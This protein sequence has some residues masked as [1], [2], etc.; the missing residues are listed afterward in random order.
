[1]FCDHYTESFLQEL[2]N[3]NFVVTST[4]LY[5]VIIFLEIQNVLELIDGVLLMRFENSILFVFCPL[6]LLISSPFLFT[7]VYK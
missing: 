3:Q 6:I 5:N 4:V 7:G 1:M 2:K